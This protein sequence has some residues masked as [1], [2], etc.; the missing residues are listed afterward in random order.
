MTNNHLNICLGV[1][2]DHHLEAAEPGHIVA[3]VFSL[4]TSSQ[5]DLLWEWVFGSGVGKVSGLGYREH[6]KKES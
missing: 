2:D 6:N 4:L 5:H 3:T 1:I